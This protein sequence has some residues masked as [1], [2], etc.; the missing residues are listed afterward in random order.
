M[1]GRVSRE[2]QVFQELY[3]NSSGYSP[4]GVFCAPDTCFHAPEMGFRE[5]TGAGRQS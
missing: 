2:G 1:K 3:R 5:L 4:G